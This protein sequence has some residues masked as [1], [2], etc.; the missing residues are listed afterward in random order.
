VKSS[1]VDEF[2]LRLVA[3]V[4]QAHRTGG[5]RTFVF[6]AASPGSSISKMVAA[7]ARKIE[8]FG[9]TTMIVDAAEIM[10]HVALPKDEMAYLIGDGQVS[11]SSRIS[12]ARRDSYHIGNFSRMR[13]NIDLLFIEG[14]PLLSSAETEFA[15]RLSDITVIVAESE[16]TTRTELTSSLELLKRLGV[17]GVAAVLSKV[18]TVHADDEFL[19]VIHD[20]E[21]RQAEMPEQEPLDFEKTTERVPLRDEP[22]IYSRT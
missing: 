15:A 4:D 10:K 5:A 7:L 19:A 12:P 1:V 22:E 21:T 14:L 11:K 16:K 6:T 20:V 13:S 3:G 2:M 18:K 9:Y 8:R 17:P